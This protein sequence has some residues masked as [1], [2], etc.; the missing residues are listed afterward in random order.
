MATKRS[1]D[2]ELPSDDPL[3][4]D[5]E[6]LATIVSG[7]PEYFY[8]SWHEFLHILDRIYPDLGQL[9]REYH[10]SLIH[11]LS[12]SKTIYALMHERRFILVSLIYRSGWAGACKLAD[13][14]DS[15]LHLPD[16]RPDLLKSCEIIAAIERMET[17][18]GPSGKAVK[19][20]YDIVLRNGPVIG[21]EWAL[22]CE[23][24][25]NRVALIQEFRADAPRARGRPRNR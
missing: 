2:S 18:S 25:D 9:I 13:I 5:W 14:N 24:D 21:I 16:D 4:L 17:G 1:N 7:D 8:K 10:R 19:R 6:R 22:Q 15:D 23:R 3:Q 20:S 11:P 12:P